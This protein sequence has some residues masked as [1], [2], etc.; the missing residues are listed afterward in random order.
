MRYLVIALGLVA[1][2]GASGCRDRAS[3]EDCRAACLNSVTLSYWADFEEAYEESGR[4]ERGRERE[5]ERAENRL[6]RALSEEGELAETLEGCVT[7]CRRQPTPPE[8][9]AC[10][11]EAES[12][13]DLN[14]CV[15]Q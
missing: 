1:C 6:E 13:A 2:L 3:E 11:L 12:I 9:V 8:I 4:G 14:R 5:R 15:R 7:V 10:Q